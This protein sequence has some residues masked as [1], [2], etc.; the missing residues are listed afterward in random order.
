LVSSVASS[1]EAGEEGSTLA[2]GA[3]RVILYL[4]V[5]LTIGL[6]AIVVLKPLGAGKYGL[7]VML[8]LVG[9]GLVLLWRR[10][11]SVEGELRS[12]AE[13]IAAALAQPA[14]A[15]DRSLVGVSLVPGLDVIRR[16]TIA[17]DFF[18]VGRTLAEL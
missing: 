2:A 5:L 9:I 7:F 15:S 8:A 11:G 16:I 4:V 14:P 13:R 1:R 18:A 3:L 6:P 10:A 12:A 17:P